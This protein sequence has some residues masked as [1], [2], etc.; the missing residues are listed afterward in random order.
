MDPGEQPANEVTTILVAMRQGDRKAAGDLLPAV[1]DRL[2]RLAGQ[3][4]A[5]EKPGQTLQP[6]ALVHEA[7]LRLLG[8]SDLT[9]EDRRHFYGAAA[10]AMRRI[11]VDR[12]RRRGRLKHG[13]GRRREELVDAAA[14]AEPESLDIVAVDE[15]I[16]RLEEED[17]RAAQVVMLQFFGGLSEDDTGR[18]LGISP[19]T[20]RREWVYAKAWLYRA[21]EAKD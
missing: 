21:L 9:W 14:V 13:A 3:M 19:R 20:V 4:L 15:A 11:L 17:P 1:Y 7:Y 16:R 2:R 6:T 8:D 12:A 5:Q 18:A 10:L